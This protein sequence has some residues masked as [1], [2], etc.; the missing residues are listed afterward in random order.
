MSISR[1]DLLTNTVGAAVTVAA[2]GATIPI[3]TTGQE[4]K[5][6]FKAADTGTTQPLPPQPIP[7]QSELVR[8]EHLYKVRYKAAHRARNSEYLSHTQVHID[9]SIDIPAPERADRVLKTLELEVE[10]AE[11]LVSPLNVEAIS[12]ARGEGFAAMRAGLP[13]TDNPYR[14]S[15]QMYYD[16][17]EFM[18]WYAGYVQGGDQSHVYGPRGYTPPSKEPYRCPLCGVLEGQN[19]TGPTMEPED[20]STFIPQEACEDNVMVVKPRPPRRPGV[21]FT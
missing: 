11:S 2:V 21:N 14:S 13:A 20:W 9:G 3:Q 8:W 5:D 16:H 15:T 7:T 6:L 4:V 17:D 18:A 10:A 19:H 12:K 1:R